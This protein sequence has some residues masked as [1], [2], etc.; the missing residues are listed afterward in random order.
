[1]G[2]HPQIGDTRKTAMLHT[3]KIHTVIMLAYVM[4]RHRL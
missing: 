2:L 4:K 1:M 3:K